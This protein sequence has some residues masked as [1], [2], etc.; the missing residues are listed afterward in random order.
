MTLGTQPIRTTGKVR[1]KRLQ[2]ETAA[3]DS[4]WGWQFNCHPNRFNR[5]PNG[6]QSPADS[7][8]DRLVVG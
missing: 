1:G 4:R 2:I 6:E 3:Q 7:K 5:R 8:F